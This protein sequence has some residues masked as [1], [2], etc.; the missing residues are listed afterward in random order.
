[1]QALDATHRA[2][3]RAQETF[4]EV[5]QRLDRR[6]NEITEMQRL[7]EERFRQEWSSFKA[8]D[9]KRWT[10]YTLSQEEQQK[11]TGRN[12][13][14]ANERVVSLE[15]TTQEIRDTLHQFDEETQRQMQALLS[16]LHQWL[17]GYDRTF[18][19]NR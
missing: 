18:G 10:N 11:E 7:V 4:D 8:D 2:V 3:K 9:Q 6:V 15:D 12:F 17:E 19:R 5:N 1:M 14:K 16:V 13:D